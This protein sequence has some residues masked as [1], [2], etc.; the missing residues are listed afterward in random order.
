MRTE[1]QRG[2]SGRRTEGDLLFSQ[3]A[4]FPSEVLVLEFRV[5][6]AADV[7]VVEGVV[8][9]TGQ[10]GLV[11]QVWAEKWPRITGAVSSLGGG[12]W[13]LLGPAD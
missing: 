10:R 3:E 12:R 1:K 9:Q 5:V 4:N 6:V 13:R 11:G 2:K 8:V 7:G